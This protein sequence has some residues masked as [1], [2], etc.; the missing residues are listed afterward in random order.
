MYHRKILSSLVNYLMLKYIM[1]ILINSAMLWGQC[2]DGEVALW[3]ECYSIDFTY[4]LD[5]SE[6]ELSGNLPAEISLLSNL[7]FLD[8]SFNEL[9]GDI[10]VELGSLTNLLGLDLSNNMFSGSNKP[11]FSF[12]TCTSGGLEL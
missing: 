8:L 11:A 1:I 12:K 5:L 6:Q 10:P 9:G 3:E 2:D 4:E 7:M